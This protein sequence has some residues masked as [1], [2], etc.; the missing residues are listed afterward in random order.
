MPRP[1]PDIEDTHS[2]GDAGLGHNLNRQFRL[3]VPD[4]PADEALKR[5]PRSKQALV[6]KLSQLR[7]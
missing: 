5:R 1:T 6:S 7:D 4:Q 2:A 3:D